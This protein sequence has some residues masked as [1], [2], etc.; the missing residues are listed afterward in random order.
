MRP[1]V[2][3]LILL[4]VSFKGFSQSTNI[5]T[6]FHNN[7]KKADLLFSQRAYRN[8]LVIYQRM[9]DKDESALYAKQQIAECYVKLN[10]LFTAQTWYQALMKEP[11]VTDE[12][13]FKYAQVLYITQRY[14]EAIEID[15]KSVV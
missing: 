13:K 1:L 2:V 3:A 11:N 8:A 12:T 7:R 9:V 6:F 15:R 5:S 4:L 14:D 10:D